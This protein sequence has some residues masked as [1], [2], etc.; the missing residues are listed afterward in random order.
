MEG[1]EETIRRVLPRG[2]NALDRD[3]V[4]ASQRTRLL[5]AIGKLTAEQ[6]FQATTIAEIVSEAGVAKPTFYKYFE[7]KDACLGAY[8]EDRIGIL[9]TSIAESV[10]IRDSTERRI[11]HGLS[12]LAEFVAADPERA[13]VILIES[14]AA[15]DFGR[16]QIEAMHELFA[17][18]YISLREETRSVRPEVPPLSRVRAQAIVGA[19]YE[20]IVAIVRD[21]RFEDLPEVRDEL[22]EAVTMLATTPF[23]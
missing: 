13:R 10:G 11:F 8:L 3:S 1:S 12:A 17:D 18:F 14:V 23:G 20:P 15:G 5:E 19:I 4:A 21:D 7:S 16:R 9:V 6:G 22:I 2:R